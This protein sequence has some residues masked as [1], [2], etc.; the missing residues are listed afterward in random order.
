MTVAAYYQQE[1]RYTIQ[2]PELPVVVLGKRG[3]IKRQMSIPMELV[4]V[5]F[6]RLRNEDLS[7]E[8]QANVIR[9]SV[10]YLH[11]PLTCAC[12]QNTAMEPRLR[13]ERT[14]KFASM[15]FRETPLLFNLQLGTDFVDLVCHNSS[16][17]RAESAP[18]RYSRIPVACWRH[19]RYS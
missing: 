5:K 17:L 4:T 12:M 1:Y 11:C 13:I 16:C 18:A 9:V 2:F 19:R 8:E 7:P 15:Y 6:R 10:S 3:G 14:L